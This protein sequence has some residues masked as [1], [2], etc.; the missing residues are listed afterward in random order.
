MV[1]PSAVARLR[2]FACPDGHLRPL[3]GPGGCGASDCDLHTRCNPDVSLL[4]ALHVS[5]LHTVNAIRIRGCVR[6]AYSRYAI[7]TN[8][9]PLRSVPDSCG[10]GDPWPSGSPPAQQREAGNQR[11]TARSNMGT[12]A[13]RVKLPKRPAM[14]SRAP[15]IQRFIGAVYE[16]QISSN[17]MVSGFC[18]T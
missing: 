15:H 8:V 6:I 9:K 4:S 5:A 16:D 3:K 11:R 18:D 14:T 10:T 12:S 7:I 2:A 13:G 1:R 17:S